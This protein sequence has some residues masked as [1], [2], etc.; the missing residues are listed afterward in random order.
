[1]NN[2]FEKCLAFVLK[3]EGGFALLPHDPGGATNFGVTKATYEQ[4]IGHP[5]TVDDMRTLTVDQITPLYRR[6]FWDAIHGDDLPAGVDYAVFDF[7]VNSGVGRAS[8]ALQQAVGATADGVIGKGTM[9]AVGAA[10]AAETIDKICDGRLAFLQALPTWQ[11]FGK[12]WGSRVASV[13]QQAHA[14][15]A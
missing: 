7:A 11:Y 2:N 6:M 14:M 15:I 9:A 13:K 8:K 12:G 3:S 4:Y 1:M 5:V 10:N